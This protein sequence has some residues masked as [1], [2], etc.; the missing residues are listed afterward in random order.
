MTIDLFIHALSWKLLT[1]H[2]ERLLSQKRKIL[3]PLA[4]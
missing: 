4:V 1:D 3:F 2:D